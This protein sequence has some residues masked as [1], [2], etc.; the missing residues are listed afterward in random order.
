MTAP[1]KLPAGLD[2][3]SL[4]ALSLRLLPNGERSHERHGRVRRQRSCADLGAERGWPHHHPQRCELTHPREE[5][6]RLVNRDPFVAF[7]Q[8]AAAAG[9]VLGGL[10]QGPAQRRGAL[11]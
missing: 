10:D 4:V 2:Q 9:G 8:W 3:R 11:A 7:A 5:Y 1:I 6:D